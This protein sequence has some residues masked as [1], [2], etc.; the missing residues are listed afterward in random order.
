MK[1]N[2]S[3][4]ESEFSIGIFII[5]TR[6]S[7]DVCAYVC[8]CVCERER[9]RER[10]RENVCVFLCMVLFLGLLAYQHSWVISG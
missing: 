8:V 6:V 10:K 4:N 2:K 3:A 1:R 5:S 9:E 7:E